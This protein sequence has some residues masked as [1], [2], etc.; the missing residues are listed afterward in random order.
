MKINSIVVSLEW[1][2]S[3]VKIIKAMLKV[4]LMDEKND[5]ARQKNNY[6]LYSMVFV[7]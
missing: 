1:E 7:G 2:M 4:I 6:V 5:Q 3:Q